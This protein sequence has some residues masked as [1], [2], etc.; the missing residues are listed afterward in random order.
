MAADP[1][2]VGDTSSSRMLT[3]VGIALLILATVG[4]AAL[5][6]PRLKEEF[7][8]DIFAAPR[9]EPPVRASE[10][11]TATKPV[12]APAQSAASPAPLPVVAS[13]VP[14]GSLGKGEV[15]VPPP[16]LPLKKATKLKTRPHPHPARRAQPAAAPRAEYVAP[17]PSTPRSR[18]ESRSHEERRRYEEP[19]RRVVPPPERWDD[20]RTWRPGV[21][22]DAPSNV[23]VPPPPGA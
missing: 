20:P 6:A 10:T 18:A 11:P 23:P 21:N 4:A 2:L 19:R 7:R 3:G 14:Q 12:A 15:E 17:T 5:L 1:S 8:E 13:P 9:A 16:P 22:H